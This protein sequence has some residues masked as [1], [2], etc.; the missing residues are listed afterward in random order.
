MV[1]T[2][3]GYSLDAAGAGVD[4]GVEGEAEAG[5]AVLPAES[6]VEVPGVAAFPAFSTVASAPP[7]LSAPPA[8]GGFA[9]EYR[10]LYQPP[11]LK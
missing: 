1:K 2:D 8:A 3:A 11:P 6:L 9:E 5:D 4:V 10:S 7:G